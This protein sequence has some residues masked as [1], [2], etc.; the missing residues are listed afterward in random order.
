VQLSSVVVVVDEVVVVTF[1]T[2]V[3]TGR[4]DV[5]TA[6]CELLELVLDVGG[7]VVVVVLV[8][9]SKNVVVVTVVVVM[10]VEGDPHG[11]WNVTPWPTAFLRQIS[12]SVAVVPPPP[13]VSQMHAGSHVSEPSAARR[14][15]RQSL[16]TGIAPELEG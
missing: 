16:A 5:V 9:G 13:L 8:V 7:A 3:V 2:V 1:E 10:V 4:V 11:H 15:N 14:M 12:A 6:G